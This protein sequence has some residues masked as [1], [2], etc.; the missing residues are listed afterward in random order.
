MIL[1]SLNEKPEGWSWGLA[2]SVMTL[3]RVWRP[4]PEGTAC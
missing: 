1:S 2:P 3:G 4:G